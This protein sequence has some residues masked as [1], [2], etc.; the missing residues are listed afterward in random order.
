M[1]TLHKITQKLILVDSLLL[2]THLAVLLVILTV[3]VEL[4]L[5]ALFHAR[6]DMIACLPKYH[7]P[8]DSLTLF[9]S[10][11]FDHLVRD[12][13]FDCV[14]ILLGTRQQKEGSWIKKSD[15]ITCT[16]KPTMHGSTQTKVIYKY[17]NKGY[18]H[19][20]VYSSI[21]TL[22]IPALSIPALSIP[23]IDQMGTDKV[24]IDKVGIDKCQLMKWKDTPHF[25]C[26]LQSWI[27]CSMQTLRSKACEIQSCA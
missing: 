27:A 11:R 3:H 14:N 25:I 7:E 13:L 24:G 12:K 5:S 2:N 16:E 22:S 17:T 26:C 20:R 21:P 9:H 8:L 19:R 23:N 4:L 15:L 10:P 6:P 1:K 18:I